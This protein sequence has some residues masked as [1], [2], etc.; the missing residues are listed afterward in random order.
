MM[1]LMTDDVAFLQAISCLFD[2][3]RNDVVVISQV[4]LSLYLVIASKLKLGKTSA[5][6]T[7]DL[8][9][10]TGLLRRLPTQADCDRLLLSFIYRKA[11]VKF[12]RSG[13]L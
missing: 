3:S 13:S 8:L 10:V 5:S 11:L 9:L 6:L 7:N 4:A 12:T 1:H 2:S